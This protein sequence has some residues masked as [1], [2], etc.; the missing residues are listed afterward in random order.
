[1][2]KSIWEDI[3]YQFKQGNVI[4]R[5]IGICIAV[6]LIF[7]TLHLILWASGINGVYFYIYHLF[8]LPS[9][10]SKLVLQPWSAITF[11]FMHADVWHI[12][13]NMLWLYWFGQIYQL[14]MGNRRAL[15]IF[16]FGSLSGGALI[17]L[18]SHIIP[19]LRASIDF[20]YTVGAS[21]GIFAIVFAATAL[22]P[23]HRINLILIGAV[24]IKYIAV[25]SFLLSYVAITGGNAAG[26]IAH[27]GGAVFGFTYIKALQ[28][29]TDWFTPLDKLF[30]LF[31]PKS[32][33]KATYVS[34]GKNN[35]SAAPDPEQKRV[36]QILEKISKSGYNSLSKEERDFLFK[37]SNK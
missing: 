4:S 26:E 30:A 23:E 20:S 33:L 35:A 24:P 21:A 10:F 16:V 25:A 31:K 18:L 11:M 13:Y 19:P 7:E 1:M 17:L 15:H 34:M 9:S 27:I 12:F 36:D 6:F 32:K 28:A 14:Y 29:G 2:F 22:N 3:K 5:L 8:A 37:F